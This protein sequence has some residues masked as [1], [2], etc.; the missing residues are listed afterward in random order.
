[1]LARA[2]APGPVAEMPV[3]VVLARSGPLH[4][5]WSP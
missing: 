3:R 4:L 2:M 5:Y 1:V